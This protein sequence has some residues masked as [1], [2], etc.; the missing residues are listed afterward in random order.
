[1]TINEGLRFAAGIFTLLSLLLGVYIHEYWF[2]LTG[3]VALNQIQSA[4]THWCPMMW[5]LGKAGLKR[6]QVL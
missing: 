2:F 4:F 5:M 3:F 6:E 1:M